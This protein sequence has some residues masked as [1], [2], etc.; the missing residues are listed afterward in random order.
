M[1]K[2]DQVPRPLR[3]ALT[4]SEAAQA[5]GCSRDFFDKHIGHVSALGDGGKTRQHLDQAASAQ[6]GAS[7]DQLYRYGLKPLKEDGKVRGYKDGIDGPWTWA[8][9]QT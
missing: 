2:P 3:L 6:L 9:K 1:P 5:L 4:P 7:A 8:L